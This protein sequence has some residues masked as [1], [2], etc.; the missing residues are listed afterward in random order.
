[1]RTKLAYLS[2]L[3]ITGMTILVSCQKEIDGTIIPGGGGGGGN[4]A[5]QFPRL[6]TTWTYRYEWYNTPGG[7]TNTKVINHKA[8][9][10]ETLGGETWLKIVDVET[11]T[12]V[13][14][15]KIRN[16]GLYQ[17]TN[18][19]SYLFFKYP[20]TVGDFYSTYN[21]GGPEDFT[22]RSM[23]DSVST[24]IGRIPLSNYE[25]VKGGYIIDVYQYNKNA[26]IVWQFRYILVPVPPF[27]PVYT[28]Y[29]R[30][31]LENI[32]Y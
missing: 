4:P 29:S 16:D 1:M 18:N 2:F 14:Y 22:V 17:Y 6:G 31:F 26:W 13:Y 27:P 25:G 23:N 7:P 5:N 20:A 11:D 28:L 15:L 30:L 19:A 8:K 10:E 21:G 32:V 12:T 24:G 3:V 9:T